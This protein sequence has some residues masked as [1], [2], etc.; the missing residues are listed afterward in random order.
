MIFNANTINA[1]NIFDVGIEGDAGRC[2]RF[3][4]FLP[5]SSVETF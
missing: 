5:N 2:L 3:F 1:I 4:F